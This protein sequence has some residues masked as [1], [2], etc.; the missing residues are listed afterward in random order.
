M[1]KSTCSV[2]CAA[3]SVT[4]APVDGPTVVIARDLTPADAVHVLAPPTV[5]LVTELGAR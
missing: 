2:T 1:S 4:S 5:G 3:S